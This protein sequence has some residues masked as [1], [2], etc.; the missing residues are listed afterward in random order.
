MPCSGGEEHRSSMEIIKLKAMLCALITEV[1]AFNPSI[2]KRAAINGQVNFDGFWEEHSD[3]DE[4]RLAISL[5]QFSEHEKTILK[6][7][8][9]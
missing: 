5:K 2:L 1:K 8:L 3:E 4:K 7:L 9:R 6:K